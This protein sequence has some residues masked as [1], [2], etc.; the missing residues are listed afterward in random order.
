MWTSAWKKNYSYHICEI[1]GQSCLCVTFTSWS[2]PSFGMLLSRLSNRNTHVC[3]SSIRMISFFYRSVWI[4]HMFQIMPALCP[5]GQ[6][7]WGWVGGGWSTKCGQAW[8]GGGG[9]K[10]S[11]ICADILYGWP[12]S[13]YFEETIGFD[14]KASFASCPVSRLISWYNKPG[15]I[16]KEFW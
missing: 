10:N 4:A 12:L 11:Q 8:T 1:F 13:Y 5:H 15:D 6:R 14:V 2:T 3:T 9:P 16:T 7:E